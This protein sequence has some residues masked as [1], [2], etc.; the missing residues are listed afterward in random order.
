[1]KCSNKQ[2]GAYAYAAVSITLDVAILILPIQPVMKLKIKTQQKVYLAIIFLLGGATSLFSI[3]RLFTLVRIGE[4]VD[5]TWDLVDFT[6]L[7]GFEMSFGVVCATAPA[8]RSIILRVSETRQ[9]KSRSRNA[10]AH[11]ANLGSTS[12]R[13]SKKQLIDATDN[14]ATTIS[15]SFTM[16]D[17]EKD[18]HSSEVFGLA[19]VDFN[20]SGNYSALPHRQTKEPVYGICDPPIPKTTLRNKIKFWK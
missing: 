6:I 1:M 9:S 15:N 14:T 17:I 19:T 11:Q 10:A 18:A 4:Y 7:S 3:G 8:F 5:P 12:G 13:N 16:A 2:A 20:K